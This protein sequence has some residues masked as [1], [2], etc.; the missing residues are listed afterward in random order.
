LAAGF[1]ILYCHYSF[2]KTSLEIIV[3]WI[4]AGVELFYLL[5]NFAEIKE[6]GDTLESLSSLKFIKLLLRF[7]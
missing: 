2:G 4:R 1:Q 7:R 3:Y 5:D 6:K